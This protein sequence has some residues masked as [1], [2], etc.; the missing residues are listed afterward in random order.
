MQPSVQPP[1]NP[2]AYTT[3][4]MSTLLTSL[5]DLLPLP[6]PSNTYAYK[7]LS[8]SSSPSSP[9]FPYDDLDAPPGFPYDTYHGLYQLFLEYLWS[10]QAL[11]W[12]WMEGWRRNEGGE[13]KWRCTWCAGMNE[14][15]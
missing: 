6:F 4:G 9:G 8:S 12:G 13:G 3:T 7:P 5:T 15:R 1:S 14:R 10:F 11:V 2:Q